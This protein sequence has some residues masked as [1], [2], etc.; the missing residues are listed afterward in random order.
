MKSWSAEQ[1]KQID[2]KL[3]EVND[4]DIRFFRIDEFKRN[5]DRVDKFSVNCPTCK[6]EQ[7]NISDLVIAIDEA[8]NVPGKKRRE[9]DRLISRLSKHIQKE[10]GFYAPFHFTYKYSF[11]GIVAGAILGYLL[12]QLNAELKL[13]LFCMGFAIGILPIYFWGHQK[14]KKIRN[15]KMLM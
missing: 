8:V 9:Y 3:K 4:K 2:T 15:K 5:I 7:L 10:H 1:H 14:D 6:K 12:M 11:F 13:E